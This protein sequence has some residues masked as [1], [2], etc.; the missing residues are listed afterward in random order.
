[1]YVQLLT[2]FNSFSTVMLTKPATMISASSSTTSLISEIPPPSP[3]RGAASFSRP[4]RMLP[5]SGLH[6]MQNAADV[7][8]KLEIRLLNHMKYWS[9][10]F[11]TSATAL[12]TTLLSS[13]SLLY[14]QKSAATLMKMPKTEG[15]APTSTGPLLCS[16]R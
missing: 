3:R 7:Q 6:M 12:L 4:T 2:R 10:S 14:S 5:S 11:K 8:H 13:P 15:L 9:P 16:S 1:M